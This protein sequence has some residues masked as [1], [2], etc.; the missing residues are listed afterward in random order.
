MTNFMTKLSTSDTIS[1]GKSRSNVS[2]LSL[3]HDHTV[4]YASSLQF[5]IGN[6]PLKFKVCII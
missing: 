3:G 1:L 6:I 4:K 2:S 5:N